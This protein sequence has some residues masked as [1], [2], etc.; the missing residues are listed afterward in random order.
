MVTA[1]SFLKN[2]EK[3][4]L[5]IEHDDALSR[6]RRVSFSDGGAGDKLEIIAWPFALAVDS[7]LG[8]F[9]FKT[10][11]VS[12]PFA[13][14]RQKDIGAINPAYWA[15][16]VVSGTVARFSI[17]K[18][19]YTVLDMAAQWVGI[20]DDEDLPENIH[21]E[22]QPLLNQD[23][24]YDAIYAIRNWKSS[25][26]EFPNFFER[27]LNEYT[28]EYIWSLYAIVWSIRQYDDAKKAMLAE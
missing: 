12:D 3:M 23:N 10:T 14:F 2:V 17:L 24:E 20:G 21:N 16:K 18:F 11:S 26:V 28:P 13:F 9:M 4:S 8:G 1:E 19:R 7:S 27:D 5:T 25:V 6:T 15:E 22:I